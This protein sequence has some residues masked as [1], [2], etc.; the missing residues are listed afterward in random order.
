MKISG[1]KPVRWQD[2]AGLGRLR[3]VGVCVLG[4]GV[5]Q[6]HRANPALDVTFLIPSPHPIW[7]NSVAVVLKGNIQTL[8]IIH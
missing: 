2:R 5:S 6:K 7:H 4:P 3:N 8:N 1:G